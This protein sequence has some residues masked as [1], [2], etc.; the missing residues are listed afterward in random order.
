MRK[1]CL[2]IM[3]LCLLKISCTIHKVFG[4]LVVIF[5]LSIVKVVVK[6]IDWL[7][8]SMAQFCWKHLSFFIKFIEEF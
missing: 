2:R 6:G 5:K 8:C 4:H 1:I 3:S 7:S